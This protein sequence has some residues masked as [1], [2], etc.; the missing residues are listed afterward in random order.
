MGF[1]CAIAFVPVFLFRFVGHQTPIHRSI[2]GKTK[3]TTQCGHRHISTGFAT[4]RNCTGMF[5]HIS[6]HFCSHHSMS[7]HTWFSLCFSR[8]S[9]LNQ[10]WLVN[11]SVWNIVATRIWRNCTT[12]KRQIAWHCECFHRLVD[13]VDHYVHLCPGTHFDQQKSKYF[14][15]HCLHSMQRHM[16]WTTRTCTFQANLLGWHWSSGTPIWLARCSSR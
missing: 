3:R 14:S 11:N 6:W 9:R 8:R 10:R 13:T 2:G 4:W 15:L 16:Q 12:F 7:I 1:H 5:L